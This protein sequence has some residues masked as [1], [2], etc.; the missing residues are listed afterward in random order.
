MDVEIQK[1]LGNIIDRNVWNIVKRMKD[2]HTI[3]LKWVFKKNNDGRFC[4]RLVV[5]GYRQQM[6]IDYSEI[7]SP[8]V[9]EVKI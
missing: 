2:T 6:G 4:A 9:H 7:Y 1:E 5:L 8:M 3:G